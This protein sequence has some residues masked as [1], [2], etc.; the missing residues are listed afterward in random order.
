[1]DLVCFAGTGAAW[2][3]NARQC[4]SPIRL[5]AW[6]QE[7]SP[8]YLHHPSSGRVNPLLP[9][10]CSSSSTWKHFSR[11][12]ALQQSASILSSTMAMVSSLPEVSF[13]QERQSQQEDTMKIQHPFRYSDSWTGTNLPVL[14]LEEAILSARPITAEAGD[15][16][17]DRD[18]GHPNVKESG[19]TR[20]IN[21]SSNNL[22][23]SMG[24]WPDPVLRR[25]AEVVDGDVWFGTDTL[26]NAC[27]ILKTTADHHGAVGLAAQQCG[28]NARIVYV[29]LLPEASST[30]KRGH[31][32]AALNWPKS[33]SL[34]MV[35]PRI[36]Q[37]SAEA[38]M[39]C[40]EEQCLVLPPSF[41]VTLLRDKWVD[42]QYWTPTGNLKETRLHGE[43]ARCV[44]H[45]LDHD[46]GILTLDH[47]SLD[48]MESLTVRLIEKPEHESRMNAAYARAVEPRVI[49][50]TETFERETSKLAV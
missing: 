4:V 7:P 47:I 18:S 39:L 43:L 14:S 40:W 24:R 50:H 31:K 44:Q 37:R 33:T 8:E 29:N 25:P 36:V 30:T 48:E 49:Q 20:Y 17:F 9:S 11:R 15:G 46:R 22:I 27:Q 42:L 21:S 16:N 3:T 35:N 13:A 38:E 5:D 6:A 34:L 2:F 28:I 12:G 45:E 26:A 32:A 23:W 10:S 19:E 1:M 41:D